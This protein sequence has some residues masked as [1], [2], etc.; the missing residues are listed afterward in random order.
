M[1]II[2][3]VISNKRKKRDK[4]VAAEIKKTL[5][6]S[7]PK[8]HLKLNVFG[9][10]VV[11]SGQTDTLAKRRE[12]AETVELLDGVGHVVNKIKVK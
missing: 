12:I 3:F 8:A 2:L 7:F 4:T 11:L 10:A 9:G 6:F 1:S 5:A